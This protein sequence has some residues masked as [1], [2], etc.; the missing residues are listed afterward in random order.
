MD[1]FDYKKYLAEGK[2]HEEKMTPQE[3]YENL[4]PL[5][6]Y[7][8]DYES[9]ISDEIDID[10][11]RGLKNADDV[12][13]Y[14]ANV[15]GWEGDPDLEDDLENIYNQVKVKFGEGKLNE[16]KGDM[17]GRGPAYQALDSGIQYYIDEF[18]NDVNAD[19]EEGADK[20]DI[21]EY[22]NDLIKAIEALRDSIKIK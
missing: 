18:I 4:P 3:E 6:K 15:R 20:A 1:N 14:Y 21:T 17:Y 10:G 13:N 9:N 8:Y 7:I 16:N 19:I 2:L 22:L 12:Y 11:I 5:Q